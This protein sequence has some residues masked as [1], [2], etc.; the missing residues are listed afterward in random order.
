MENINKRIDDKINFLIHK[1]NLDKNTS[2]KTNTIKNIALSGG[3]SKGIAQLG[4]LHYLYHNKLLN[5]V[6]RISG[7]SVGAM[8][9]LLFCIGYK[10][11]D[12]YKMLKI[13]DMEK[14]IKPNIYKFIDKLGMEDGK[15]MMIIIRRLIIAKKLDEDITFENIYNIFGYDLIITGSCITDK[16]VYYFSKE[17]YPKMKILD[18]IRI[19]ISVPIFFTPFKFNNKLFVDGGCMD[20]YPIHIFND[21]LDNTIGIFLKTKRK[22]KK[23]KNIESYISNLIEVFFEGNSH[24]CKR[25]F[26]SQTIEIKCQN[27]SLTNAN[28]PTKDIIKLF[29][30]GYNSAKLFIQNKL[31]FN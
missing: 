8:N 9:A 3:A 13:V 27:H 31:S 1:D 5:N 6:K 2:D 15:R 28:L 23:I 11:K 17:N 7:T 21:E 24:L 22:K 20:N 30:D 25:S 12:I 18:A 14:A 26:Q 29:D 19:S 16:Q 4:A 10:P